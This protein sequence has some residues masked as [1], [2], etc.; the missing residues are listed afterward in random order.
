MTAANTGRPA[1]RHALVPWAVW[2]AL[3]LMAIAAVISWFYGNPLTMILLFPPAAACALAVHGYRVERPTRALEQLSE[4]LRDTDGGTALERGTRQ[5]LSAARRLF[6]AEYAEILLLPSR[7]GDSALRSAGNEGEVRLMRPVRLADADALA[8]DAVRA[9]GLVPITV[10][11]GHRS[12]DIERVLS[13]RGL[14]DAMIG[15]LTAKRDVVGLVVIGDRTGEPATFV[16]DDVPMFATFCGHA[17]VVLENGRLEQSLEELTALKEQLRHQAFHDALTALPNRVLF[18]ERV[19]ASIDRLRQSQEQAGPT[20]LFLDLDD[21][22]I[23]NDTWGHAAGD[24]LLVHAA[25]RIRRI[26]RPTDTPARL[27]GDEFGVLLDDD[28]PTSGQAAADRISLAFLEPF[29]VAGHTVT[30]RPSIGIA[31]AEP[32]MSTEQLLRNA[33]VAMYEAKSSDANRVAMYEAETH[34][35][36]QRRRRLGLALDD[37][38]EHHQIE[39]HFQPVVALTDGT[40]SA[41]EALVRWAHPVH[42]MM[43]PNEFLPVAT[44]RQMLAI[45]HRVIREACRHASMWQEVAKPSRPVGLWVNLSAIELAR[46]NLVDDVVGAIEG[47]RLD[48]R[49]LTLEITEHSVIMGEDAAI[50]RIAE[51]R[52]LGVRVAIDDFGTG[53]S[54]L[55]RLGDFPL[56][57]LKIPKPFVDKL[58]HDTADQSLVDA[59]L[60]LAGSLGLGTVAEGV[61]TDAQA[62]ILGVLGCP[63]VQGYLYA[64]PLDGDFIGRLLGSGM[65]LPAEHGFRTVSLARPHEADCQVA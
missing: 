1:R 20:V 30:V 2:S 62:Q 56:D 39:L 15:V 46:P 60:R 59:I 19:A 6:R 64:P 4:A 40:I 24:E 43:T 57:M 26:V 23:V 34:E 9:N 65:T 51:L 21:F 37:A 7:P 28:E 5:L 50:E 27:G 55:S 33:D 13:A 18:T 47:S 32:G 61:E 42:G 38:I 16:H 44:D 12:P 22:K 41:M 35:A 54:S 36:A 11:T 52:Q 49:L 31:I 10:A 45:G 63:L 53:Y 48:P 58:V 14:R 3:G 8:I 25:E 29:A 17:A